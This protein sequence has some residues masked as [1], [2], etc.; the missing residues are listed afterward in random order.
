MNGR[1]NT[2]MKYIV[3]L[4]TL[5]YNACAVAD[6]QAWT[7]LTDELTAAQ[8]AAEVPA[9]GL[10]IMDHNQP[11]LVSAWGDAITTQTPFR[12]GSIS[13]T[14]TALALMRLVEQGKVALSDPVSQF[15]PA[16]TFGNPWAAEHPLLLLHLLELSGGFSDLSGAE[17]ILKQ[18]LDLA[19]ALAVSPK[20]RTIRWP[21]GLQ[22]SYTNVN[23]GLTAAVIEQISG[24]SFEEFV[25]TEV[26]STLGMGA[27]S[28]HP[29]AGLP[30]GFKADGHTEIPYWHMIFRAFGGLNASLEEMSQFLTMLLNDGKIDNRRIFAPETLA[31]LFR[32]RSGLA[33]AAGL[34]IGYGTGLYGWVSHGRVFYGHAAT[35]TAT[36]P[37]TGCFPAQVA[38]TSSQ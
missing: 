21:P 36:A 20:T 26:L 11:A 25:R 6:V 29:V 34:E 19:A 30:G 35:Q 28:F 8:Y 37:V 9:M 10:V 18:P 38:A 31:G 32:P 22:S 33:A 16:H 4:V 3:L 12:W 2:G 5:T 14:F 27:A 23:P 17:F 1:E 13:K 15:L 7:A 24:Q